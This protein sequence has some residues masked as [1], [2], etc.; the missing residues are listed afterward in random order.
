MARNISDYDGIVDGPGPE[1]PYG[2][3]KDNPGGTRINEKSNGDLHVFGQDLMSR[4]HVIPNGQPDNATHGFQ[5]MEAFC[6]VANVPEPGI[7]VRTNL[8]GDTITF[9]KSRTIKYT[10]TTGSPNITPVFD[11][12]SVVIGS[13]VVITTGLPGAGVFVM[14]TAGGTINYIY[15]SPVIIGTSATGSFVFK[16]VGRDNPALGDWHI[17]VQFFGY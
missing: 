14:P 3:I 17:T 5:M 12:S 13:E 10:A 8:D 4:A 9:D 15:L 7:E 16:V 11:M 2:R 1:Y 6:I